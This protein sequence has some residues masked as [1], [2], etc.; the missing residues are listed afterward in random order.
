MKQLIN[1]IK[2]KLN[3][4]NIVTQDGITTPLFTILWNNQIEYLKQG[5]TLA[6]PNICAF[7]EIIVDSSNSIGGRSYNL[8]NDLSINIHL[9]HTHYSTESMQDENL[10]VYDL[11]KLVIDKLYDFKA[12]NMVAIF[13]K[14]GETMDFDHDNLYHYILSY[15][16]RIREQIN[17]DNIFT[18]SVPPISLQVNLNN[19]QILP[20]T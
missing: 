15:K 3:S 7:I 12:N 9:L 13:D 6:L 19:K 17:T 16:T 1:D 2:A 18:L 11:R 5:Q 10:L 14:V 8:E 20:H 4:I